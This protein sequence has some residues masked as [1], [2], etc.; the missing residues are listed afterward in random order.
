MLKEIIDNLPKQERDQLM[1][2]FEQGFSQAIVLPNKKFLGVNLTG[3]EP[4]LK[5]N[6]SVGVWSTGDAIGEER[7]V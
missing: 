6:E 1:Y 7:D 3:H 4:H 5:I 2:A